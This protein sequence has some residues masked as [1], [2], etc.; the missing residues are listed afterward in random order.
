MGQSWSTGVL[1]TIH[2]MIATKKLTL[3]GLSPPTL[4]IGDTTNTWN[5]AIPG[6]AYN[7]DLIAEGAVNKYYHTS[8]AQQD[9]LIV[10]TE[11]GVIALANGGTNN[12]T[13]S[14]A[15]ALP[16]GT[17]SIQTMLQQL[18]G[19]IT[20]LLL[21]GSIFSTG[22]YGGGTSSFVP[23][24]NV[25]NGNTDSV[26]GMLQKIVGNMA[27]NYTIVTSN[28]TTLAT[29]S[30]ILVSGGASVTITL[31]DASLATQK[32]TIKLVGT[33]ACTIVPFAGQTIE[34]GS[35]LVLS[36]QFQS[37]G[38]VPDKVRN[39]WPIVDN[40]QIYLPVAGG[41]VTG[42]LT[43]SGTLAAANLSGTNTGDETN[44]SIAALYGAANTR[45][46]I[47]ATDLVSYT[48]STNSFLLAKINFSNFCK[49]VV[50]T[51][52]VFTS[53]ATTIA[54]IAG[55]ESLQLILQKLAGNQSA[56]GLGQLIAGLTTKT[57]PVGADSLLIQ[58]SASVTPVNQGKQLSFTNLWASIAGSSLLTGLSTATATAATATDSILAA[59]G[60]LQGQLNNKDTS[61]GYVGLTGFNHNFW[62]VAGT[63]L[64][65]F[66]NTNTAARTY[67][68]Q[69][70]SYTV[71]DINDISV[72]RSK[73]IPNTGVDQTTTLAA[74]LTSASTNQTALAIA[75]GIYNLTSWTALSLSYVNIIGVDR[76]TT[77]L[78]GSGASSAVNFVNPSS[79]AKVSAVGINFQSFYHIFQSSTLI[80]SYNITWCK[81]V[82]NRGYP[83]YGLDQSNGYTNSFINYLN[84]SNNIVLNSLGIDIRSGVQSVIV[85]DNQFTNVSR[86]ETIW[87][88]HDHNTY[89]IAIGDS[90][91]YPTA[92]PLTSNIICTGNIVDGLVSTTSN[93]AYS[94]N[95]IEIIGNH[96]VITNN[97]V[98]NLVSANPIENA[99]GI[100]TELVSGIIQGN[101]IEDGATLPCAIAL[102]GKDGTLDNGGALAYNID[103]SGNII[104]NTAHATYN[105]V[106]VFGNS[107]TI[108]IHDNLIIGFTQSGVLVNN[109]P[110]RTHVK[111]NKILN[112]GGSP[113][114]Y[115][116]GD[117][118]ECN[119]IDN[120]IKD[121]VMPGSSGANAIGVL[122]KAIKG[123]FNAIT[124]ISGGSGY[125]VTAG[126]DSNGNQ[127]YTFNGTST[128]PSSGLNGYGF[129]NVTGSGGSGA[130]AYIYVLGGVIISASTVSPGTGYTTGSLDL[131]PI[132]IGGTVTANITCGFST[133]IITDSHFSG[134]F[135]GTYNSG[136]AALYECIE[137]NAD[138]AS[139]AYVDYIESK[140][141]GTL[142]AIYGVHYSSIN[143][144]SSIYLLGRCGSIKMW[145]NTSGARQIPW[146][147]G[148]SSNLAR[149]YLIS[150]GYIFD[151]PACINNVLKPP[152][153][154]LYNNSATNI[155][156]N[157]CF[158]RFFNAGNNF[159]GI[160]PLGNQGGSII[161][162]NVV[163]RVIIASGGSAISAASG[164][165]TIGLGISSGTNN[166]IAATLATLFTNGSYMTTLVNSNATE[167][168]TT[169]AP[170]LYLNIAGGNITS[171]ANAYLLIDID[172]RVSY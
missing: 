13:P 105:G 111:R 35:S 100:Y 71:A 93:D 51:S 2:N 50:G 5:L 62:N 64:S 103:C 116:C 113:V 52:G 97:M 136:Q 172:Y 130:K 83:I 162:K 54:T 25:I 84:F 23:N 6:T 43:V 110:K 154:L 141:E 69:D 15:P 86:N 47:V 44:G 38:I 129:V 123:Q 4:Y 126:T 94:S 96:V 156:L 17:G 72:T 58:D 16:D 70:K 112:C 115:S 10:L 169:S 132:T 157:V 1:T 137:L 168:Y 145:G 122:I 155:T 106:Q 85:N 107:S 140:I 65:N 57:T 79:G 14:G 108:D 118:V 121:Q 161:I 91:Q 171:N 88:V 28:Y 142:G 20:T 78:I 63:F 149:A 36:T 90:N 170:S 165:P 147:V 98:R 124:V 3:P 61:G 30:I 27:V 131:S 19:S 18:T 60:K 158:S 21:N 99:S 41:T 68:F 29:D 32:L 117:I 87:G 55:T 138:V 159:L 59:I 49:S 114:Y 119:V 167:I 144:T 22:I 12:F 151:S 7:T 8:Q 133:G 153:P 34:A 143:S 104:I 77:I 163:C 39:N 139:S 80:N 24:N 40:P 146:R 76:E 67:T 166:L 150:A 134:E 127:W 45:S 160:L 26:K 53:W 46:V 102:K 152:T 74:E 9:A 128:P 33:H 135:S 56:N 82:N 101:L 125:Q 42:N 37:V 148:G 89:A 109:S 75:P 66:T 73:I 164:T 120:E 11:A 95:A 92:Q 81:F 48:D 31:I